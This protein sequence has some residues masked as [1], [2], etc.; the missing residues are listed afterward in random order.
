MT[1]RDS[2]RSPVSTYDAMKELRRVAGTQLEPRFVAIFIQLLE[3]RD[4]DFQHDEPADLEKELALEA[5]LAETANTA[6]R[7]RRFRV[8]DISVS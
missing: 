5:R 6:V 7:V 3:G 1:A 4:V 8:P 2:Y